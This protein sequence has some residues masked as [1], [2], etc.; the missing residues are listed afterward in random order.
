[1]KLYM[2]G[3]GGPMKWALLN[4]RMGFDQTIAHR[5]N[6]LE[7]FY[8]VADWQTR[9]IHNFKS[10]MLDSGAYT[11]KNKSK[12]VA[13][14]DDYLRRYID[15]INRYDVSLFF[16]LDIDSI[17]GYSNVIKLRHTLET[18]TGK[19]CIPVWHRSR[20]K[21]EW[22]HMCNEYDYVAVGGI[23]GAEGAS[24]EPYLPWMTREAHKRGTLVHGLGFTHLNSLKKVGFDSVDSTAWLYGNLAG[25]IYYWSGSSM[26][27]VKR[28]R[29]KKMKSK[30]VARHNFVEW[31]RM[32]ECLEKR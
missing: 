2:A 22:L 25:L 24:I 26:I 12:A 8:Y 19:K 20:G 17:I 32:A 5:V 14:W 1:M 4:D 11:F 7:S 31:V 18:E 9:N 10:F 13:D 30:A 21:E 28:P 6:L 27:K 29:S 23:A 16:E 15:Y 3:D